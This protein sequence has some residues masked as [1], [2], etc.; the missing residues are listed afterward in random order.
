MAKI[1]LV[2]DAMFVRETIK[3][4]IEAHGHIVVGEAENGEMAI[5]RYRELQPE[6]VLLDITMPGMSGVEALAKI[7]DIDSTAKVIICSSMGQQSIIAEAIQLGAL[8]FIIKPFKEEQVMAALDKA[9][10]K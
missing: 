2:D 8:D 7:K 3:K 6:L 10:L 4:M 1:L 9:L 5:E